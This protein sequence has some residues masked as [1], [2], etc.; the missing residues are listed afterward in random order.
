MH[1]HDQLADFAPFG[2][3]V[4]IKDNVGPMILL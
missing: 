1:K 4:K 2:S 3:G